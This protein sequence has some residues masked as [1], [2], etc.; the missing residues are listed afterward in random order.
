MVEEGQLDWAWDVAL[1]PK[2]GHTKELRILPACVAAYLKGR[3]YE[4]NWADVLGMMLPEAPTILASEITR[5]LNVSS[6]HTYRLIDGKHI[7]ACPTRR[8]GPGGS[9]RVPTKS[10]TQFL[11]QRRFP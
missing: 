11:Q 1:D 2:R 10:F 9:A 3:P 5:M 4:L 7:V 6:D 8:R